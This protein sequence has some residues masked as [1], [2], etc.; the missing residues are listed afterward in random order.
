[1]VL[2]SRY[3]AAQKFYSEKAETFFEETLKIDLSNSYEDFLNEINTGNFILD[4]GCGSGRD[5]KNFIKKGYLV[6]SW[7]PNEKL[8]SLAETYLGLEV[9][10]ASSY[11]LNSMRKYDAIWAS[12]SLLHLELECFCGALL[13]VRNALK[14]GGVF[15]TSFKWGIEDIQKEGRFFL[16][17]NE[18]R[19]STCFN[20]VENL[21]IVQTKK[22]VDHRP[23]R[24]DEYWT[25]CIAIRLA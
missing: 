6:E 15:Y 17:M 20:Q 14:P 23:D 22:R 13:K 5:S 21:K 7:E 25:E 11:E 2:K 4:L 19:L 24:S 10:R 9:K 3:Q 16:M 18:D 1:V 12:A 8:A